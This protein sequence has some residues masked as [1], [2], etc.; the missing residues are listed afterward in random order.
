M[1][2]Y[3]IILFHRACG[4]WWRPGPLCTVLPGIGSDGL[5]PAP[6]HHLGL[7]PALF[8]ILYHLLPTPSSLPL[9]HCIPTSSWR[10]LV[11]VG[12]KDRRKKRKGGSWNMWSLLLVV[13]LQLH[14]LPRVYKLI[15]YA[16]PRFFCKVFKGWR[17]K[18][19]LFSLYQFTTVGLTPASHALRSGIKPP[20][21]GSLSSPP[22][23]GPVFHIRRVGPH[24]HLTTRSQLLTHIRLASVLLVAAHSVL[25]G[26][27]FDSSPSCSKFS[28]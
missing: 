2:S 6:L 11:L 13:M 19:W 3:L 10:F 12:H 14:H 26:P 23:P 5:S 9:P 28:Y 16:L 7:L 20:D 17:N 22:N 21:S 25:G 18:F 1:I 8:L 24:S 4:W 15:S 27:K